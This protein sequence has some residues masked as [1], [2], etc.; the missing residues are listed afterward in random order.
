MRLRVAP[1][2]DDQACGSQ[3]VALHDVLKVRLTSVPEVPSKSAV[4]Q[5]S[6]EYLEAPRRQ[7]TTR[8]CEYMQALPTMKAK[9][10]VCVLPVWAY[11]VARMEKRHRQARKDSLNNYLRELCR[12]RDA[13]NC[14][15]LSASSKRKTELSKRCV[16]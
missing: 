4:R 6:H 14:S 15:E 1:K 16:G 12:R 13:M 10:D 8:V 5:F 3:V 11:G 7:S 9:V 2:C